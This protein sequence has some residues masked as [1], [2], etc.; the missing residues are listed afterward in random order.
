MIIDR[1]LSTY[2]VFCEDS[3]LEGLRKISA[4]DARIVF[5]VTE[6][7]VLEGV[8]TN[9]DFRRWMNAYP[10]FDVSSLLGLMTHPQG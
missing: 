2:I 3:I 10:N 4:N 9:G 6:K 5:S 8:L 1:N 7:G